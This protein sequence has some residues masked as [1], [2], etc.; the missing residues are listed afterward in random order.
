MSHFTRIKTQLKEK[1]FLRPALDDLVQVYGYEV[2][3]GTVHNPV[4]VRG[5]GGQQTPCEIK[6]DLHNRGYDIGFEKQQEQYAMV[7]D[8]W[9][10]GALAGFNREQFQQRVEQRYAYHAVMEQV[11][12]Q[13]F[14]VTA[15]ETLEDGAIR[16]CVRRVEG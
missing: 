12:Q 2:V 10:G 1:R 16:I 11:E 14:S 6:V 4:M 9:S 3:E 15:E 7:A 8:W 13:D 5:Y